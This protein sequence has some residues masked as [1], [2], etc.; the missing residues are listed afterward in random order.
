MSARAKLHCIIGLVCW[1][2]GCGG[3]PSAALSNSGGN[4]AAPASA[5]SGGVASGGVSVPSAGVAAPSSGSG[6]GAA[7]IGGSTGAGSA[8]NAGAGSPAAH[9]C[10]IPDD[11]ALSAA[12]AADGVIPPDCQN[13]PRKVIANNCIGSF[14]HDSA[15]LAAGNLDLMAPCVAERLVR[16]KSSCMDMYLLDPDHPERSFFTD[17]LNG[18]PGPKC[19]KSMPDGARLPPDELRCINAWISAVLRAAKR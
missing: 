18:E 4:A 13:V 14:C 11:I 7:T 17:K 3:E 5:A 1:Q 15:G 12:D 8:A 16:V 10:S 19:G 9:V 2:L 6:S